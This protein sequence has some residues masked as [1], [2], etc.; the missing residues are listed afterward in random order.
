MADALSIAI[1]DGVCLATIDNPSRLNALDARLM[2]ELHDLFRRIDA[3]REIRALVLTGTGHAFSAGAD[4]SLLAKVSDLTDAQRYIDQIADVYARLEQLGKPTVAAVN[5]YALGGGLELCLASD[6]VLAASTASFAVPE[7][8]LGL[9][10]GFAAIRLPAAIGVHRAAELMML[11]ERI[12]ADEALRLGLVN[13][14]VPAAQLLEDALAL[15]RR[16]AAGAPVGPPR[17]QVS[18]AI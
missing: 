11:G 2:D 9:M 17:D 18:D 15:G 1:E 8:Q 6:L 3:D 13:S 16:L 7:V 10:P 14:V 12:S 5:G 4:I